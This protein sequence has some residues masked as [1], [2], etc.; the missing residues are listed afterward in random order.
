MSHWIGI[1][2]G[3]TFHW[4]SVLD[5]EGREVL[6]RKVL[7]TEEDIE[8]FRSQV[9]ALGAE[10]AFFCVDMMGGPATLLEAVLPGHGE[11]VFYL[12]GTALNRARDAYRGGEHKSDPRDARVIADQLRMRW[13]SLPEINPRE[14]SSAEMRAL[15][16]HRRDL[17]QDQVRRITRMRR[18]YCWRR[19]PAWRR[20]STSPRRTAPWSPSPR[21][22]RPVRLAGSASRGSRGG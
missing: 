12:S 20:S 11:R 2:V 7:A 17:V 6:S 5:D 14:E 19:S 1:D 10:R 4:A 13:R 3:K 9:G 18:L 16:A 8:A 15:L 21:W 22:R